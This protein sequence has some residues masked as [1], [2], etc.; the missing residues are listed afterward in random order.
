MNWCSTPIYND[1]FVD[2]DIINNNNNSNDDIIN[3]ILVDKIKVE[4][5]KNMK[6]A[7]EKNLLI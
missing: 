6:G 3:S 5:K 2:D 1:Y 4:C 7:Q